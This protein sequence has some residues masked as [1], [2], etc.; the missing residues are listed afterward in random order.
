[1][2]SSAQEQD[3]ERILQSVVVATKK[4]EESIQDVPIA[5]SAFD[6]GALEKLQL[7]GGPDRSAWEHYLPAFPPTPF[8]SRF[9][10]TCFLPIG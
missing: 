8:R 5:V 7:A 1:M 4:T 10:G 9:G 6:E 3:V 2:P